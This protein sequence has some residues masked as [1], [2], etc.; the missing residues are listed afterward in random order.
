MSRV[1]S[2][3]LSAALCLLSLLPAQADISVPDCEAHA[4]AAGQEAGIPDGIMPAIARVESGRNGRAWPWTLNQGG[5][6]SYHPTKAAALAKLT[7]IL[8]TG[9]QNVDLG[10]MQINWRWHSAEF[11]NAETMMDPVANTRY[12]ARYLR[13][14]R[15]QHGNWDSAIQAYHSNVPTRGAAY[16]RK[17][18]TV[19][20]SILAEQPGGSPPTR[21][22]EFSDPAPQIAAVGMTR[23]LL[24]LSGRPMIAQ[25]TSGDLRQARSDGGLFSGTGLSILTAGN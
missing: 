19:R 21:M 3:P 17:V 24:A 7:E 18:A 10:C 5:T 9:V 20:D 22:A 4:V 14:L 6:G 25:G 8:S 16:G 11:A 12:S 1:R 23:G 13:A 15:D 2:F